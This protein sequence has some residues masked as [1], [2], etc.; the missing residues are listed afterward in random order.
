MPAFIAAN[1]VMTYFKCHNISPSLAKKPLI[2]DTISIDRRVHFNQISAVLNMP[3]EEIRVLNPQ[4]RK[5]IIPGNVRPYKLILPSQQVY[6]Y[7]MSEDSILAYDNNRY[8]LRTVV[9]PTNYDDN[10]GSYERKTVTKYHKVRR[11]ES[12]SVIARKYG[13]TVSSIK[14]A[15]GLR[16]DGIQRGQL[17]K[18]TTKQRVRVKDAG[19]QVAEGS[20]AK[21]TKKQATRRHKVKSGETLSGIAMKYRGVTVADIRRANGIRG[22]KIRAGQT[23]L[24]P[25]K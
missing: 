23:L 11:G 5:D 18:I 22:S 20:K 25:V 10:S 9:N 13:V 19:G 1:Y 14:R 3:V 16:G 8:A 15:N 21:S 7:I 17:L 24:I 4:Y 2:T 6:S 12:L